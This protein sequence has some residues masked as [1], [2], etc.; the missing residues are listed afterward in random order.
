MLRGVSLEDVL[1]VE[2]VDPQFG[3]VARVCATGDP[4]AAASVFLAA[5]SA[6]RLRCTG[7]EYW[8]R[9][10]GYLAGGGPAVDPVE[11]VAAFLLEDDCSSQLRGVKVGRVRRFAGYSGT[12][13]RMALSCDFEGL[14][15]LA[16]GIL[17]ADPTS[18]TVVFAVKMSYYCAR[19]AGLCSGPLPATI[20][21]PLDSRVARATLSL[22][23]VVAGSVDE[24][25]RR[26]R[27]EVLAAWGAVGEAVGV[28]PIHLDVLL[29]A[30]SNPAT[31]SRALERVGGGPAGEAFLRLWSAI[32]G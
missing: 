23:M 7:E 24:L 1:R 13:G 14:W 18:K 3:A 10:A 32:R 21:I 31:L 5:L 17:G 16:A 26:C 12:V 15:R 29:W 30:L 28:P 25:V 22:G 20:P 9:V 2:E 4:D 27:R 11:R 8:E 19:A 6:Y